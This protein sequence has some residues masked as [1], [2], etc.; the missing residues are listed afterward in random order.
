MVQR[1]GRIDRLGSLF[2]SLHIYN[3]F[4]ERALEELLGLVRSLTAKIEVINQTGFLD[5]AVN[6]D[7][8]SQAAKHALRQSL[9]TLEIAYTEKILSHQASVTDAR[10]SPDGTF[11]IVASGDEVRI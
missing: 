6:Q 7:P 2:D 3:M 4:P 8:D 1:A 5:A 10:F 9:A 11:I